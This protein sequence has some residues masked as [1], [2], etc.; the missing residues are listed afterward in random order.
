[1]D[2]MIGNFRSAL[3]VCT[4]SA[5]RWDIHEYGH[6]PEYDQ[7]SAEVRMMAKD[8]GL[9][10]WSGQSFWDEL[11]IYKQSWNAFHHGEPGNWCNI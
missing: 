1:M 9:M 8:K 6:G 11:G 5:E 3:Y 2:L 4:A 10:S 7:N